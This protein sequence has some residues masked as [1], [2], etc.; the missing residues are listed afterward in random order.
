MSNRYIHCIYNCQNIVGSSYTHKCTFFAHE[1]MRVIN[2]WGLHFWHSAAAAAAAGQ[3]TVRWHIALP[4]SV[5]GQDCILAS[6]CQAD[7]IISINIH[8][9][10]QLHTQKKHILTPIHTQTDQCI[11][12]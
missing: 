12:A 4:A 6:V 8:T 7:V 2:S 11:K 5:G 9:K 3:L 1:I 10:T